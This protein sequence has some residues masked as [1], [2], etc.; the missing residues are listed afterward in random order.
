MVWQR[1]PAGPHGYDSRMLIPPQPNQDAADCS[2]RFSVSQE[3]PR[4]V[5][6]LKSQ[7]L[8]APERLGV[9]FVL[10]LWFL[11]S[12]LF[13]A[14]LLWSFM[15]GDPNVSLRDLV[16]V[17]PFWLFGLVMFRWHWIRV[18]RTGV[19]VVTPDRVSAGESAFF[20]RREY[21]WPRAELLDLRFKGGEAGIEICSRGRKPVR[22][23]RHVYEWDLRWLAGTLRMLLGMP[24]A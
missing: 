14:T 24:P 15:H 7:P 5:I 13:T 12:S 9:R 1:S 17:A 23:I 11:F 6:V 19:I 2:P 20:G 22:V 18:R 10:T 16:F 3:G 21:H 4:T 8:P